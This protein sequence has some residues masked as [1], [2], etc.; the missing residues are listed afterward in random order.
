MIILMVV[1]M[2]FMMTRRTFM[3]NGVNLWPSNTISY[4]LS[5]SY[6]RGT[7]GYY[8]SIIVISILIIIIVQWLIMLNT[9]VGWFI[10]IYTYWT[11]WWILT[12]RITGV[13]TGS[14]PNMASWEISLVCWR[15]HKYLRQTIFDSMAFLWVKYGKI[16]SSTRGFQGI[17]GYTWYTGYTTYCH[18]P[19]AN[20]PTS[21][22]N[23]KGPVGPAFHVRQFRVGF[24]LM[25]SAWRRSILDTLSTKEHVTRCCLFLHSWFGIQN[26]L[27]GETRTTIYSWFSHWKWWFPYLC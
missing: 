21:L 10:Y 26:H 9:A 20:N 27:F 6:L 25:N 3:G 5:V 12:F 18:T 16:W 19:L 8:W 17:W 1:N 7:Y 23:L 11:C 14:A 2:D 24:R 13:A 4:R 22:K 15:I